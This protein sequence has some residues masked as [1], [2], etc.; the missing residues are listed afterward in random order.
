MKRPVL[1]IGCLAAEETDM[2][3]A[4]DCGGWRIVNCET[5]DEFASEPAT[6]NYV[7]ALSWDLLLRR[8]RP[9]RLAVSE[10][11][12]PVFA[13]LADAPEPWLHSP[14][15]DM[16]RLTVRGVDAAYESA[17]VKLVVSGYVIDLR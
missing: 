16:L 15:W 8:G 13:E 7:K 5:G 3:F 4:W 6:T 11:G 1:L 2:S 14:G 9:R 10:N 17:R 12:V